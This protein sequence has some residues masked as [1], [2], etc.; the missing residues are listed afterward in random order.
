LPATQVA[1][2]QQPPWQGRLPL[3]L[4]VQVCMVG[5]QAV[6]AGQSAVALQPQA[7]DMHAAP[8]VEEAQSAHRPPALPQVAG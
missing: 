3:Q 7:P 2:S 6:P 8:C 4:V 1:P 5:S